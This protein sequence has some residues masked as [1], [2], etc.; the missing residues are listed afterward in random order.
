MKISKKRNGE[1]REARSATELRQEMES[2]GLDYRGLSRDQMEQELAKYYW[3]QESDQPMPDQIDPMLAKSDAASWTKDEIDQKFPSTDWIIQEKIDGL[4]CILHFNPSGITATTRSRSVK[5]FRFSNIEQNWKDLQTLKNPF[6]KKTI[7]DGELIS[8]KQVID[9]GKTITASKLQ[10]IVALMGMEP[11]NALRIQDKIGSAQYRVFD[12]IYFDGKSVENLPYDQREE[13]MNTAVV[14]IQQANPNCSISAVMSHREYQSA[15]KLFKE[16][17]SRGS[18][19]VMAKLRSAPY[20]QG[21]RSAGLQKL[22]ER[23][24]IDGFITGFVP[25]TVG[26]GFENYIGGFEISA[27]VDGKEQVIAA[28]SNIPLSIRQDA[29]L[30]INGTMN[31]NP[32]YLNRCV[33]LTGQG[34]GKN[35]RLMSAR[36]DDWRDDKFPDQCQLSSDQMQVKVR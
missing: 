35:K 34:W 31:L 13:L 2:Y 23:E 28:V 11:Q 30:D 12:I 29:T 17:L 32:K 22:K 25:S 5:N 27:F 9:T 24:T 33:Q 4:R 10:A 7:L 1:I 26:K 36:I 21:H 20:Q 18:E 19:G 15:Y 16:Y 8:P 14:A 3:A 6:N